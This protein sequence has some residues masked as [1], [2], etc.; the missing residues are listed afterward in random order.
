MISDRLKTIRHEKGL[1]QEQLGVFIGRSKAFI[2][3]VEKGK[4][5]LSEEQI[6]TL[7]SSLGVR[8]GWL[9]NGTGPMTEKEAT[10]D[11][12]SIGERVYQVR[13]EKKLSQA[14]F[15]SLLGVSRNTISLLERRKIS[16][17]PA[18]IRAVV[19]KL[20]IDEN[21]LRSGDRTDVT[22]IEEKLDRDPEVRRKVIQFLKRRYAEELG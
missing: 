19:E 2:S 15:A 3:A 12:R 9:Q 21:W 7:C 8:E 11:R 13:K 16:A 20:D 6:K 5:K 10:R 1:T 4:A 22:D 18:I 14:D 17:S